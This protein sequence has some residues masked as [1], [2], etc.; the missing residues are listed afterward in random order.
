MLRLAVRTA[1]AHREGKPGVVLA[2]GKV[3]TP[4]N[5]EDLQLSNVFTRVQEE[6]TSW[7]VANE[8]DRKELTLLQAIALFNPGE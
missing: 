3:V 7:L 8:I 5:T 2:T 4:D 1:D 6:L